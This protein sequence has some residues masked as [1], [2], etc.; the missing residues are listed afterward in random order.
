[1]RTELRE[2]SLEEQANFNNEIDKHIQNMVSSSDNN[3]KIGGVL[4]ICEYP[5]LQFIL[6]SIWVDRDRPIGIK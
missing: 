6:Q 3:E 5:I 2:L 4:T 1:M